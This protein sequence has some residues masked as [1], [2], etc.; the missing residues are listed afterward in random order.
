MP[1]TY[2][3][4]IIQNGISAATAEKKNFN[5]PGRFQ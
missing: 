3:A 4:Q 1:T 5:R 2:Y